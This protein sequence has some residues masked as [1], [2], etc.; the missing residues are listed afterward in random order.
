[1]TTILGVVIT[2]SLMAQE[3]PQKISYQGKLLESGSPVN[4]TKNITFTIGTWSETKTVTVTD[5]LYS[6][7]LGETTPIPTSIFDNTSTVTLQ[8]NVA[9][10]NLTPQTDILSVPYAYK[11]EKSVDAK[12]IAGRTVSTT[13]PT[14]NQVLKWNGTS[15]APGTDNTG[16]SGL[17]AQSGSDIYYNSGKVGIGTTPS[18]A[19][20]HVTSTD[21]NAPKL[22][23]TYGSKIGVPDNEWITLGHW[24]DST[25]TYTTRLTILPTSGNVGIG[26]TSPYERFQIGDA[27]TFRDGIG[28]LISY[29]L[30]YN[31]SSF[32][33]MKNGY[34]NMIGLNSSDA[35]HIEFVTAPLGTAGNTA[36]L[37]TRMLIQNDGNV[38]IGTITPGSKLDISNGDAYINNSA[39]GVILKSPNG[40]CWRIAVDN[41]GNLTTTSVTCP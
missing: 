7:T 41:T 24:T 10:T 11:A 5:G 12:Q 33:Y 9:G 27:W 8:I 22:L 6:V 32:V 36:S 15:W 37:N 38:G 16:S 2:C 25:S 34:G 4:G 3:I 18:G 30:Y 29:N 19:A 39:N 1:M 14:T 13:A 20:L 21:A 35:G 26:S 40:T 31:G 17:W 23:L 28:K